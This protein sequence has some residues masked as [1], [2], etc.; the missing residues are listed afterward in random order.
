MALRSLPCCSFLQLVNMTSIFLRSRKLPYEIWTVGST[1]SGH[2]IEQP[3]SLPMEQSTKTFKENFR[4]S[5]E[6]LALY[7]VQKEKQIH[8]I[9]RKFSSACY[10]VFNACSLILPLTH[11]DLKNKLRMDVFQFHILEYL[12]IHSEISWRQTLSPNIKF[13]CFPYSLYIHVSWK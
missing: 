3:T 5:A 7:Y 9:W 8:Y 1:I 11:P 6:Y 4:F 12:Y 13:I 2:Q 10:Q